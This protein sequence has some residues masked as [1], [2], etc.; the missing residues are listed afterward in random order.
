MNT[1]NPNNSPSSSSAPTHGLSKWV[2]DDRGD[3]QRI[4]PTRDRV[5]LHPDDPALAADPEESRVDWSFTIPL[6]GC[7]IF[8]FV[9][10]CIFLAL[11]YTALVTMTSHA[12]IVVPIAIGALVAIA[13]VAFRFWRLRVTRRLGISQMEVQQWLLMGADGLCPACG[14]TLKELPIAPDGCRVCPECSGAWRRRGSQPPPPPASFSP[15]EIP[16]P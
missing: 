5:L 15:T 4:R 16:K 6:I 13:Y 1:D 11:L 14:Y 2:W 9:I 7:G 8:V 10:I 3:R 12:P